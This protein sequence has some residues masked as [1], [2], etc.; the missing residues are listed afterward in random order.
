MAGRHQ[1]CRDILQTFGLTVGLSDL[2]EMVTN[3]QMPP[4]SD[5]VG[6]TRGLA[7]RNGTAKEPLRA[8]TLSTSGVL[9]RAGN[10]PRGDPSPKGDPALSSEGADG[11]SSPGVPSEGAFRLGLLPL[12]LFP[13]LAL[14]FSH[15]LH[16]PPS[17]ARSQRALLPCRPVPPASPVLLH[18]LL[19]RPLRTR[20]REPPR[21]WRSSAK[22]L[23]LKAWKSAEPARSWLSWELREDAG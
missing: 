1:N 3:C 2:I 4:W 7:G 15:P 6:G 11:S 22:P 10:G 16:A 19:P 21:T 20:P 5:H 17:R 18:L 13:A 14:V 12:L 23:L 9:R 8:L